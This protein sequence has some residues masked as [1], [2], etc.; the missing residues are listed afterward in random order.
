MSETTHTKT[1]DMTMTDHIYKKVELVGTSQKSIEQAVQ[2]A[3][4]KASESI[5]NIRWFEVGEIRGH[6]VGAKVDHWQV[7]VKLGFTLE[8][9]DSPE[10]LEEKDQLEKED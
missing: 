5:R 4:T 3:L 8:Q 2:N 7:G 6:V 10:T 9:A 1:K